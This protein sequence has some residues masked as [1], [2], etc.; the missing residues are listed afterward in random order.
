M[1]SYGFNYEKELPYKE[2]CQKG[3]RKSQLLKRD[4]YGLRFLCH[5]LPPESDVFRAFPPERQGRTT[6]RVPLQ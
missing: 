6:F 1:G 3:Q 4:L 2:T 5:Q